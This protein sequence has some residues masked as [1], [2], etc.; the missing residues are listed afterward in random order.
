VPAAV[1]VLPS[2][3]AA[4]ALSHFP[5]NYLFMAWPLLVVAVLALWPRFRRRGLLYAILALNAVLVAFA[6]W[7]RFAVPVRE[8]GLAWVLYFPVAGGALLLL[9]VTAI[10]LGKRAPHGKVGA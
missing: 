2:A 7:V 4:D 5:G 9:L 6:L 1:A 3:G 8:S 10:V